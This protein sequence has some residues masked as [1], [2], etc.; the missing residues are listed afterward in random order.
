MRDLALH[1]F[2]CLAYER[3]GAAGAWRRLDVFADDSGERW[4]PLAAFCI[5]EVGQMG[6]GCTESLLWAAKGSVSR[7]HVLYGC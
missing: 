5:G 2:S 4:W 7:A 6:P 3:G 1:D